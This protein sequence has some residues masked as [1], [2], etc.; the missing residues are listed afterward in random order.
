MKNLV[1]LWPG[2][3]L[4]EAWEEDAGMDLNKTHYALA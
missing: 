2:S 1:R 3:A 4:E